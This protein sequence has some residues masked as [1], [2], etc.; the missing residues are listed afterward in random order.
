MT[1][2]PSS[3]P[4]RNDLHG[5]TPRDRGISAPTADGVFEILADWRR[6]CVCRFFAT[7]GLAATHVDTLVAGVAKRATCDDLDPSKTCEESLRVTLVEEHLPYL[8]EAG[9]VDFDAR[10]NW[11]HYWGHPTVEKWAEHAEAVR[12]R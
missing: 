2:P 6:R 3:G 1:N 7:T 11:V 4:E 8:D 5:M 10:S 9:V 12:E